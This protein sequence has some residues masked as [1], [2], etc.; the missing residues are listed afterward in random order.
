ML[1]RAAGDAGGSL[2]DVPAASV[3]RSGK[4]GSRL[5][6][7]AASNMEPHPGS[8]AAAAA[9]GAGGEG[10]D[11]GSTQVALPLGEPRAAALLGFIGRHSCGGQSGGQGGAAAAGSLDAA[12]G[13]TAT[14]SLLPALEHVRG[15]AESGVVAGFQLAAS[16]GPLCD[17]P[18]W[19]V[20]FELELRLSLP[21]GAS[22][23]EATALP[24]L[25]ED[26]YGPFSGQVGALE[27]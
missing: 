20:A 12:A 17:E 16:S 21:P 7:G 6:A 25:Q 13:A 18:M 15:S 26:V 9:D 27:L 11:Q 22:G 5:T 14:A 3:V 2:F 10:G 24:D 19:G 1:N 4:A 23:Q 8:T